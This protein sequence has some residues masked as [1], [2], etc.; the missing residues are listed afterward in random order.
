MTQE[1]KKKEIL[2][3]EKTSLFSS[4]PYIANL[5]GKNH[6]E[7]YEAYVFENG[8]VILEKFYKKT[9]GGYAPTMNEAIY[10]MNIKDFEELSKMGK[11]EV[12]EYA[13]ANGLDLTPIHH[14][15]YF[16]KRVMAVVNSKSYNSDVLDY[17]DQLIEKSKS[18]LEKRI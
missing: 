17:I 10:A 4:L 8:K 7:G 2:L 9:R 16:S 11:T 1:E 12:R 14:T 13:K 18:P 15:K 3:E 6:F 5:K